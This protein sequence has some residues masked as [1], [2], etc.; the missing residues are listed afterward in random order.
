MPRRLAIAISHAPGLR[1]MPSDGHCSRAAT[2]ASWARSSARPTSRVM[3]ASEAI[4]LGASIFQ[5]ASIAFEVSVD[6]N[7]RSITRFQLFSREVRDLEHAADLDDLVVLHRRA[8]GP[9]DRFFLRLDLD[10]PVAADAFLRFGERT[11]G[12]LRLAAAEADARA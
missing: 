1:G 9:L 3:R 12:H 5:T 2:S 7:H 11:V 4:S 10:H 6:S 8:P